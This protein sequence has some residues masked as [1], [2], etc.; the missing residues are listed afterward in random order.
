MKAKWATIQVGG[1]F[2]VALALGEGLFLPRSG[3]GITLLEV[4]SNLSLKEQL[5]ME[6]KNKIGDIVSQEDIIFAP[7]IPHPEK[8]ICIGLNYLDHAKEIGGVVPK[9]PVIFGKFPSALTGHRCPIVL[10]KVSCKVDFEIELVLVVGKT[11]RYIPTGNAW[12]HIVGLTIGNDVSARDWQLEK[13]GKQWMIGK[14]F[15]TFAPVGPFLIPT[16]DVPTT[17]NLELSLKL[18]GAVMQQS[19]TN[20]FLF[21]IPQIIN[22]VSTVVTLKPGDLIFTGTPAGVGYA[23]NPPIF[24]K[25][26]DICEI[27]IEKIG[28]LQNSMINE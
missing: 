18:N 8:V 28:V 20:Q 10:P 9:E 3:R 22:Y 23:R 1:E 12:N 4:I 25:A 6:W 15:D 19:C 16:E 2:S 14:S 17:N 11:G 26:G 27:E 13:D 21:S 7:L 24:M 5:R